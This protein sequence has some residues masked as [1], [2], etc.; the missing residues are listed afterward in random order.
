M[1][2]TICNDIGKIM[3]EGCANAG[4]MMLLFTDTL[5]RISKA[6]GKET[7]RQMREDPHEEV[8][9]ARGY[10]MGCLIPCLRRIQVC[11]GDKPCGGRRG[12]DW[13][14]RET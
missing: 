7:V 1:L 8:W 5:K 9:T 14:L 13:I 4:R 3:L 10:W 11:Y 12:H 6:D 2:Q